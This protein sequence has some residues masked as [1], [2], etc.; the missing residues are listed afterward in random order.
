MQRWPDTFI[1]TRALQ[2]TK[3]KSLQ[4]LCRSTDRPDKRT[5]PPV[6]LRLLCH[7]TVRLTAAK[8]GLERHRK[9]RLA[10]PQGSNSGSA[11]EDDELRLA[12]RQGSDSGSAPEDDELRLARPQG[13]DSG[14]AP[15]DD[16]LRLAR[17]Q[18][19]D[20]GSAPEDDELRLARP[21][22][23]DSALASADSLRLA[24]PRGSDS[25]SASKDRLDLD[26]GGASAL[27]NPGL[28]P[29]TS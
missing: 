27:P 14:S 6:P 15:E 29:T 23:S 21:Q 24:R 12:R 4:S 3:P 16:E 1:L 11:P 5:A 9:L 18:G 8:S 26:L 17:P 7:S 19:S 20:S 28:G 2:S 13:S 10:R 25:T 22:G